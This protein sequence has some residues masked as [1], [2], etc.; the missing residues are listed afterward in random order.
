MSQTTKTQNLSK[1]T[2]LLVGVAV[3]AIY[4]V[5]PQIG[6]F[7]LSW[8]LLLSSELH[9]MLVALVFTL[10]TY[11]AAAGTYRLLA[12][13]ALNYDQLVVIE[14]AAMFVNKLLPAGMG[15]LGANYTYLRHKKHSAAA[16]GTI[17]AVNNTLG[18]VGHLIIL[19]A[20]LLLFRSHLMLVHNLKAPSAWLIVMA[21]IL[22]LALIVLSARQGKV[23]LLK[24]VVSVRSQMHHYATQPWRL[25]GGLTTSICLTL[26]NLLC[27]TACVLALQQHLAFYVILLVFSVGV[28]AAAVTPTPGG[29]GGFEA[30][31]AAGFIAYHV[32]A[33]SALAI[34]LLYRLVSYWAPLILGA[35]A[36][37]YAQRHQLF[38]S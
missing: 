4:V 35:L 14:L 26:C 17:V 1:R 13:K 16:A 24:I 25:A 9:W 30:G 37:I 23:R 15:A 11:L 29:L 36:F 3:V 34:A 31:L 6:S 38:S 10:L 19:V 20:T 7:R 5:L 22:V 12:F 32:A 2:L 18:I 8:H 28:S 33:P 27:L 21:A